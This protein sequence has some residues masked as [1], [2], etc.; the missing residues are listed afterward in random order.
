MNEEKI[1]EVFS[2]EEFVKS[3]VAMETPEEVQKALAEKGIDLSIDEIKAVA[4]LLEKR[5]NGELTDEDLENVAGGL[6]AIT[7]LVIYGVSMAAF[8]A[9]SAAVNAVKR[10]RRW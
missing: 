10:R 1:K 9:G 4:E 2:D 7:A 3:L 6:G 5:A 8:I